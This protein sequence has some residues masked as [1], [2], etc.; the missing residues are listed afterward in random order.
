MSVTRIRELKQKIDAINNGAELQ[1]LRVTLRDSKDKVKR[2]EAAAKVDKIIDEVDV[3]V[4]ERDQLQADVNR[5]ARLA[6]LDPSGRREDPINAPAGDKKAAVQIYTRALQRH[7]IS[8]HRDRNGEFKVKNLALEA[9]HSDVRQTV[10]DMNYRYWQAFKRYSFCLAMGDPSAASVEDRNIVFGRDEEMR[11][12]CRPFTMTEKEQR[13]M[14]VGSNTLGGYFVPQGFVY[15]IEEALKYYGDMLNVCEILDTATGQFLPYPTDNDTSNT[16]EIVGE[17]QQ[18]S[19]KDVSIGRVTFGAFKFSTKM[20]KVSLE[21]LQDSAFDIEP[22]LMKKFA[23]RLGRILN[24]KFTVGGGT[25]EPT[26]IVTALV[27]NQPGVPNSWATAQAYGTPVLAAGSSTNTGGTETGGTS[28]GTSDLTNLEHSIDPLYRRGSRYSM[29]DQ[30]LRFAKNLLDKYGRPLWKSGVA[31]GEPDTING[32]SY[33]IN[34]DLATIAVNAKTV[35]FGDFKKY[36]IRRVKELGVMTLR[37]RFADY[38]QLAYIGFA[39]YDGNLLDA[40][41]HPLS[42]LQQAAS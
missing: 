23:I 24:T 37:E 41:T 2:A 7:G 16:G 18:V 12:F 1:A 3:L 15:E 26:G 31:V 35:L 14:G 11:D 38:G 36:L 30:S 28:F 27:A 17:G 4:A 20:V 33:S 8:V 42:Y 13:D 29:H 5:E 25:T 22:Y 34:N 10:E 6:L 21:L 39:R 9:V 32:Y 19:A 40:G